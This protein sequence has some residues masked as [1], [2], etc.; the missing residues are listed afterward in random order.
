MDKRLGMVMLC[1]MLLLG[2]CASAPQNTDRPGPAPTGQTAQPPA[3][4]PGSQLP[5]GVLLWRSSQNKAQQMELEQYILG[6]LA[7]EM[8]ALFPEEALKAQAVAIRTRVLEQR[9]RGGCSTHQA[10]VCDDYT[11]CQQFYDEA[12]RR[13]QWGDQY[14]Q[15]EAKL[16][17][18]VEATQGQVMIYRGQIARVYYHSCSALATQEGAAFGE[19]LP[20]LV[21]VPAPTGTQQRVATIEVGLDRLKE[22]GGGGEVCVLAHD[23]SGRVAWMQ[24][25]TAILSGAGAREAFGLPSALFTVEKTAQGA[26]FTV[27]GSGHGVGMSQLGARAMAEGGAAWQ[28]ILLYFYPGIGLA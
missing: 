25:G 24:V 27:Y 23:A 1:I 7:G 11:C 22:I 14:P 18:C 3:P 17:A 9:A 8:P 15:Y 26:R 4:T 12:A 5:Q 13:Q 10:D 21:S 6:A 28:D 20:Y 16:K 19:T 2:G